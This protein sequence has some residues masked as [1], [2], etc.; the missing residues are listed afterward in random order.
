[1]ENVGC[2]AE[3]FGFILLD[4]ALMFQPHLFFPPNADAGWSIVVAVI[5]TFFITVV[6]VVFVPKLYR[7]WRDGRGY[8]DMRDL[9]VPVPT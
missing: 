8:D 2:I 9:M 5:F 4:I 7:K 6:L 3:H 1:M